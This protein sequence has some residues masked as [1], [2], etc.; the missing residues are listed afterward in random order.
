MW[1]MHV[2]VQVL[3][4]TCMQRPEHDTV[5][6]IE[7]HRALLSQGHSLKETLLLLAR[8]SG[9]KVL[10]IYH[11]AAQFGLF[12]AVGKERLRGAINSIDIKYLLSAKNRHF[13]Y[14]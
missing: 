6:S 4:P 7:L 1:Y 11:I 14:N 10:G 2:S 9:Q 3:A 8:P 5:S 13:D 12:W